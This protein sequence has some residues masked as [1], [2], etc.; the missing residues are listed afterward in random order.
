MGRG[1]FRIKVSAEG[2]FLQRGIRASLPNAML[3]V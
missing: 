3:Y 1:D 2:V